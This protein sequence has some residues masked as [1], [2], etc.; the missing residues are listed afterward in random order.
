MKKLEVNQMENLEGGGC[1]GSIL[2][3]L[4]VTV[5]AV[6]VT[7]AMSSVT[8]GQGAWL[9]AGWCAAKIAAT[10]SVIEDCA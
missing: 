8:A 6:G 5:G 10:V 3:S 2:N 9:L 1:A 4:A 7:I